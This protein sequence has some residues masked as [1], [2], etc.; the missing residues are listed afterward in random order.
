VESVTIS[1]KDWQKIVFELFRQ[2]KKIEELEASLDFHKVSFDMADG[3]RAQNMKRAENLLKEKE[4]MG[5]EIF[6]LR[7]SVTWERNQNDVLRKAL[8]RQT[9]RL[10]VSEEARLALHQQR[11]NERWRI[12]DWFESQGFLPMLMLTGRAIA[13][14]IRKAVPIS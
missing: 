12:L 8:D 3:L 13:E 11:Y 14:R 6:H 9:A 7:T 2:D 10:Q 5:D 1:Q 4:T